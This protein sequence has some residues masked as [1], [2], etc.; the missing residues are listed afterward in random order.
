MQ[1]YRGSIRATGALAA[2]L[3]VFMAGPVEPA[4]AQGIEISGGV[5][6]A[7]I[8]GDAVQNAARNLGANIGLDFILPVGPIGLNLGGA[9]SQKGVEQAVGSATE[10]VDLSYIELP[11]HLRFPLVG[12]GP[13]RLNLIL[14]P[15]IGINTGCEIKLD[16]G[17]AQDCSEGV[18]GFSVKNLDWSGAAGLGVSFSLGGLA[19]MGM[20]LKYAL[21]LTSVIEESTE[22]VKN[23]AFGLEAHLGFDIF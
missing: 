17:A 6:F 2:A 4:H 12:A 15:T 10:V 5:N 9:F 23:R 1:R 11:V 21:G 16:T 7:T 3:F 8:S 20:D 13:I 22:S 19:Y 14:G 18:D